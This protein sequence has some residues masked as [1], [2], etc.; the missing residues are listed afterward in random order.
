[1]TLA[2]LIDLE[3]Q[4]ARDRDADPAALAA[5]DRALLARGPV[6]PRRP[7]ALLARWLDAL[8][9]REPGALHPGRAVARALAAVRALLAVAGVGVGWGAATALMTYGGGHPVNVWDFLLAFVG[10]QAALLVL[11]LALFLL[12]LAAAGAPLAGL[13][14]GAV[15]W[16][17]ARIARRHVEPG[18]EAEWR[19]LWHRLRS[20]RS[21]YHAV[22]PWL[23]LSVTQAF[24][25]A[26]NVGALAAVLRLVVFTDVAFGWGT[27][28]VELDAT[29]FHALARAVAWPWRAL[30]PEAVP[31]EALVAATRYSRL[32]GAYLLA[33]AG[34]SARPELVGGWW[35]FLVASLLAYG[36]VPRALLLAGSRARVARLLAT[37]PHDDAEARRV[38]ARLAEPHVETRAPLPEAAAAPP[39]SG[40]R[41]AEAAP[42]GTPAALVLW[43]DVPGGD[44]LAAA[45][46]RAL[47]RPVAAVRAAG[48]G[49]H[50]EDWAAWADGADPVVVVAEAFEPP[51]RGVRRLLEDLRGALGPRR[52]VLVLLVGDAPGPG[53]PRPE[54]VRVWRDAVEALEDP[55]VGVEPLRLPGVAP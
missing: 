34:R 51:D 22:E 43:R 19:A 11:L 35:P 3:A 33:G 32:E 24:A 30:W 49:G 1:M 25:L 23:L 16:A 47:A 13:F 54:D 36:L 44:A 12:P 31:S 7:G 45:A 17:Y 21:L 18:R 48:G 39:R 4:L 5:R 40:A 15:G 55:F 27:T 41:R 28:L 52:S 37:M 2:N 20:R 26:F 6:D 38:A 42:P 53:T 14:G 50:E 9:E 8:R 10:L 29:R 46:S